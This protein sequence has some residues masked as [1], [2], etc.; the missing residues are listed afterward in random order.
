VSYEPGRVAGVSG[1]NRGHEVGRYG[2]L[3]VATAAA[4]GDAP[5]VIVAAEDDGVLRFVGAGQDVRFLP[6]TLPV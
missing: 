5:Q 1:G 3:R 6:V 4:P 2:T